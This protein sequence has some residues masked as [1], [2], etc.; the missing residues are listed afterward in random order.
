MQKIASGILVI[1]MMFFLTQ[2]Q[3]LLQ[4]RDR[5]DVPDK[6]KWDLSHLYISDEAWYE[7]KNKASENIEALAQFKGRLSESSTKLLTCLQYS[8][9]ILKELRRLSS[10][11]WNKARQDLR[12]SKYR[13]MDQETNQLNTKYNAHAAFIQPEILTMDKTTIQKFIESEPALKPYIFNLNNL[14][15]QKKHILSDDEEKVIAEA[16][17]MSL[18][19]S[20]VYNNLINTD[21]A[22]TE[23]TLSNGEAIKL[24][25]AGFQQYRSL[26]LKEDRELVNRAYYGN[27]NKWRST[28]GELMNAKV[29]TDLFNTRVRGY[30]DCLGMTL[31]PNNI[32]VAIFHNLIA[33]ANE[34]LDKF[35][36]YLR[37]RKRLLGVDKLE[38][39]DLS[40]PI[41]EDFDLNYDIEEAKE[42]ILESLKPLGEAYTSIVTKAL[43]SRWIDFYPTPG[44]RSNA[45]HDFGAYAEH[46][47]ILM[48]Y[49]GRYGDV[50][51]LTH[52]LG[53]VVH[54]YF[55]DRAQPFPT[56]NY[57]SFVAEVASTFNQKL[58]RN[59][60]LEKIE[61]DD[62]RLYILL[63]SID[64]TLFNRAQISEFEW[65]I[66]QEAEKGN[67]LTG[68][69]ISRIYLETLRKYYGHDQGIC[70]VPDLID[71]N[72]IFQRLL[73]V[74]TYRI[75]VYATSQ[76]AATSL[77]EK[78][79]AGENGAVQ[80]YLDFLSAGGSNYPIDVLKKA[81]VDL[82]S[83]ES[84]EKTMDAM[85]R[86][87]DEIERILNVL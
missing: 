81:G 27:L 70:N 32:P 83:S 9:N 39:T 41:F 19:P 16:G 51:S 44:K 53:H 3:V 66:H 50:S 63:N 18:A 26:A 65:R 21:M 52:E 74:N 47:Y 17:Q 69:T 71:I 31:E 22:E 56:S 62:A 77:A 38:F 42:L 10:Y 40:I 67:T 28:F 78:V 5:S 86:A 20:S 45:Y 11:S 72:W 68:D 35:H 33:N 2:S 75:Y 23:V 87:M 57:S 80:K 49:T 84:F 58:L 79:L 82:T 55:A 85:V 15:R 34:N 12:N 7:A 46:P 60:V 73:F 25:Q 1:L 54:Q 61:D 13:A 8:T 36:R 6:Y 30:S 14:M 64:R 29:N 59:E 37:I 4:T 24:D 76:T 43:E 48:N